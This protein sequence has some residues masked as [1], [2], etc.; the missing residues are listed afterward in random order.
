VGREG[1]NTHIEVWLQGWQPQGE[2]GK[3]SLRMMARGGVGGIPP[4]NKT[5]TRQVFRNQVASNLPFYSFTHLIVCYPP[6]QYPTST[7]TRDFME[8]DFL[9]AFWG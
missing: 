6:L 2:E 4:P 5:F 8:W 7:T 9:Q 1:R 3:P